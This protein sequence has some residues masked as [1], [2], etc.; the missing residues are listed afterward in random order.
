MR[1]NSL[2]TFAAAALLTSFGL[3][4]AST[5]DTT[6]K[7]VAGYRLWTRV[8]EKPIPVPA[9]PVTGERPLI[10]IATFAAAG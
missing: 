3:A 6:L 2:S 8:T 7:D 10:E 5:P 9:V 4:Y 1:R